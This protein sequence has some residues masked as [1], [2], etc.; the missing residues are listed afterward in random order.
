VWQSETGSVLKCFQMLVALHVSCGSKGEEQVTDRELMQCA[1][2]ALEG[3]NAY[4]FPVV[5]ELK[6]RLAQQR[7]PVAWRKHYENSG[8]TY[9]D[10]RWKTIPND[11][12]PLFS[13]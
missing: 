4:D 6:E 5:A 11:A 1:L 12:E 2:Y 8:Y 7:K 3:S 9:F 10:E 13:N